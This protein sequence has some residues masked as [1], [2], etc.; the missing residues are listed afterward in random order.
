MLHGI[1]HSYDHMDRIF[2][3][4]EAC[5][6]QK[7]I[8]K[9]PTC[10]HAFSKAK[11]MVFCTFCGFSGDEKCVRKTRE[12]PQSK[13]GERGLICKLCDRKFHVHTQVERVYDLIHSSKVTLVQSLQ[14]LERNGI[15][16]KYELNEEDNKTNLT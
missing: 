4:S 16:A 12:Y 13:N 14:K 1:M 15:S 9:C 3:L 8:K 10:H 2:F 5:G 11:E 7:Q 6:E